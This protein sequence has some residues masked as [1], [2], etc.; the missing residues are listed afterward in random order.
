MVNYFYL[1]VV[2]I[3]LL[4]TGYNCNSHEEP[5]GGPCTYETKI[6][7]ATII[8]VEKT[9]SLH[10]ELLFRIEDEYGKIY[11]DSVSWYMEN[12]NRLKISDLKKDSVIPGKK[13]K[14][15]IDLI[16]TGSCNPHIERLTLEKY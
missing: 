10:A 5:E 2:F 15:M 4:F 13:Y 11:R 3:T 12:K 8:A 16:K 6:Y 1:L 14:Y 9:D 7:P